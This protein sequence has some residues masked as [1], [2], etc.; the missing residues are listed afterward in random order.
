LLA[1]PLT[2]LHTEPTK[3]FK[4]VVSYSSNLITHRTDQ[5]LY[6]LRKHCRH[7]VILFV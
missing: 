2:L 7:T 3:H 6:S 4:Q 5:T 1:I